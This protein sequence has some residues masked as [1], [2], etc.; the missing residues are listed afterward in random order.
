[1]ATISSISNTSLATIT[2]SGT[3]EVTAGSTVKLYIETDN[4]SSIFVE[5]NNVDVTDQLVRTVKPNSGS[6]ET[7]LGTYTLVSG[8]FNSYG[9]PAEWF[10]GLVGKGVDS[11][12]TTSNYYSNGSGTITVFTYNLTFSDIPS[13]ATI[14]RLYCQ[15]NGHA[16]STTNANEYMCVQLIL[17]DTATTISDEINY[18]SIGTSNSTQTLEATTLPTVAQL[19]NLKLKCRLG[20]YG[21]AINGATCYVEYTIPGP[22]V[23]WYE[24]TIS[25]VSTNHTVIVQEP[26]IPPEEDT[27]KTYY[28]LTI[29]KINAATEPG[30]GTTR[31]ESGTNQTITITPTDPLLTLALDNGTDIT[32]QLVPHSMG[33]VTSAFTGTVDGAS[34]GFV[35]SAS[36]GYY[37]STNNGV[38]NS[39]AVCRVTLNLPVRCL[40]TIEYVNY[41]ENNYDY[42][43]FGNVDTSLDT[44]YSEDSSYY[45]SCKGESDQ[46]AKT[47]TYEITFG[48]H[49]ID[50][51]FRKDGSVNNGNDALYF[52][53]VSIQELEP[54]NYYTYDL[55]NISEDHS[56]VFIFGDV[57]YY[58]VTS[59]LNGEG[60]TFP[61]GQ[62]VQ[63]PGDSYKLTIIPDNTGATVTATDNGTD[64]TSSLER[65]E[66]ETVKEGVTS[67]TINYIYRLNNIQATHNISVSI[68]SGQVLSVKISGNWVE[69]RVV[70]KKISGVWETI[71]DYEN[72][73]DSGKIYIPKQG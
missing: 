38:D 27:A 3:Q 49:F 46:N 69:A 19:S 44:T 25:N 63:L 18:K 7:V 31:I 52:K 45:K 71:T 37:I 4:L 50:I 72:L 53:I 16:E 55:S 24:Y 15:V 47:L 6:S 67:I 21:G 29:S 23:Y 9:S 5:D 61:S 66:I 17:G 34:Y 73:F 32:S 57:T 1:M 60:K 39:A 14:T 70:K 11:T 33:T 68:S 26:Y 28:N 12:Q 62:M 42:G 59:Q 30:T 40:L 65:K 8:S 56:L 36:T 2:P 35:W 41:A 43:I 22:D 20:Y 48:Q 13:N 58:F 10:Q 51:K 64:I 54:N